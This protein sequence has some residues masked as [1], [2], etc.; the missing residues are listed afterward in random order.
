MKTFDQV[1]A[2]DDAIEKG[3]SAFAISNELR[4]IETEARC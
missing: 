3:P 2:L 4:E 1:A